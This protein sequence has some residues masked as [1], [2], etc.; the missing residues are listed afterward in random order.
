MQHQGRSHRDS[1]SAPPSS[2]PPIAFTGPRDDPALPAEHVSTPVHIREPPPASE[3]P[4]WPACVPPPPD[5]WRNPSPPPSADWPSSLP[6][7]SGGPSP[8]PS[9]ASVTS[10]WAGPPPV[11]Y[12][13]YRRVVGERDYLLGQTLELRQLLEDAQ[14]GTFIPPPRRGS[15][16]TQ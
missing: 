14:P 1:S 7:I 16:W 4:P 11:L 5:A 2:T 3:W 15:R 8:A 12:H 6:P 13:E 10:P 9:E